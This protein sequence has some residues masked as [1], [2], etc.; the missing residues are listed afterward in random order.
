MLEE[1]SR[2]LTASRRPTYDELLLELHRMECAGLNN[3]ATWA[4]AKAVLDRMN[5]II[6]SQDFRGVDPLIV[7]E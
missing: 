3:E 2:M 7:Q 1:F 4:T 5:A 6:Q